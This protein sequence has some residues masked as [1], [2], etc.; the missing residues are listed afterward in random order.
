[1]GFKL[2]FLQKLLIWIKAGGIFCC[3]SIDNNSRGE[4]LLQFAAGFSKSAIDEL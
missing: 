3:E 1:M 4:R 2:T